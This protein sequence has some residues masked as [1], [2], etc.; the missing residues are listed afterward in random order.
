MATDTGRFRQSCLSAGRERLWLETVPVE[1]PIQTATVAAAA[2]ENTP[3]TKNDPL[4][5]RSAAFR[6]RL[7]EQG[8]FCEKRERDILLAALERT[9]HTGP[10]SISRLRRELPKTA[11]ALAAERGT[12]ATTD[13]S[14]VSNFFLKLCLVAGLLKRDD[15]TVIK[16]SAGADAAKAASPIEN[17]LDVA[18]TYLLEQ[19]MKKSDVQDRE[20][21]QLAHALF[22][23]FDQSTP[24][25]DKLDR[26]AELIDR[27]GSLVILTD[28]GTYEYTE[29][30]PVTSNV[31][32]MRG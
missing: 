17:A 11:V 25:D 29:T 22:R 5:S 24:L 2:N 30:V 9:L 13:F 21:W 1:A 3:A 8:I 7:T 20:Q 19:I 23:E 32:A 16:R 18:E 12:C 31:R 15:G 27:L 26:I 14:R 10:S 4:F 28:N 6:K